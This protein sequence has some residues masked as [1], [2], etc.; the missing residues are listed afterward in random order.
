MVFLSETVDKHESLKA[1]MLIVLGFLS[2][3]TILT[4]SEDET[5]I[6]FEIRICKFILVILMILAL[7]EI[8]SGNH[9]PVSKFCDS[10]YLKSRNISA[11]TKIHLA[12]GVFYNEN[13]FSAFISIF[14][15]LFFDFFQGNKIKSFFNLVG[16]FLIVFIFIIN[17]AWICWIAFLM[18]LILYLIMRPQKPFY[19]SIAFLSFV[20]IIKRF[21]LY[22]IT[23]LVYIFAKITGNRSLLNRGEKFQIEKSKFNDILSEQINN[24]ENGVGSAFRRMYTY[25]ESIK[26]TFLDTYGFGY[27]P[28]S[29]SNF[30]TSLND[31][32]MLLNPH[33]M[34][35]EIL[36]EYGAFLFI[37]FFS[38][39]IYAFFTL[40]KLF[41]KT[42]SDLIPII[43]AIDISFAIASF[44]PSSLFAV[45]YMW[46][47]IG[48]SFA[49]INVYKK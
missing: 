3:I 36:A 17:D 10:A 7:Y 27:G 29:F 14:S 32:N 42:K 28:G 8:V 44:A 37:A 45:S 39:L 48:L 34:W 33:C 13:D 20:I 40:I 43:C 6:R 22:M 31:K 41:K 12:T 4:L 24:S 1:I 21:G 38:C 47:P 26:H 9:L 16:I 11:N 35:I 5:L 49:T 46:I 2:L 25:G 18:S 30:S 23:R 15:P 19:K